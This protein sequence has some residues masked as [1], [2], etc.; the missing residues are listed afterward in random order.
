MIVLIYVNVLLENGA[1]I[2]AKITAGST[3]LISGIL[4]IIYLIWNYCLKLCIASWK[5]YID[6]VRL[7]LEKGGNVFY[8]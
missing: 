5:C 7:M 4:Q 3:P 8:K 1:K 6:A 2:E